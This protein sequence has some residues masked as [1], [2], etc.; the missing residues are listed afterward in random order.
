MNAAV[1][2]LMT[3]PA[4]SGLTAITG[5]GAARSASRIP[6]SSRIGPIEA[7]GLDGPITIARAPAIAAR[8][9]GVGAGRADAVEGDVLDGTLGAGLDHELLKAQ[10]A[11]ARHHPGA[12]RLVAG[13]E[14]ARRDPERAHDRDVGV[15][16]PLAARPGPAP[17]AGRWPGRGRRG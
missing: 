11:P 2:P 4:T 10:P 1:G 6:G 12:D 14:H 16:Q 15:G 5:A 7:T 13:G 8:T 9:S 3:W 17:A